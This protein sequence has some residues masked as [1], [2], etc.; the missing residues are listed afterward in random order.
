MLANSIAEMRTYGEGFIIADQSPGLLDLS[1]IRNTNT[2]I[3]LR[4]PD[5]SD[6][7]LVGRAAGLGDKQIVELGRLEKGVAAITQSDW[8][9]PVLCKVDKYEE[10]PRR[11]VR[12]GKKAQLSMNDS[13]EEPA[14]ET[15]LDFIMNREDYRKGDRIDIQRLWEKIVRSKLD[16]AVKCSFM[17]YI[18]AEG[19]KAVEPLRTL[20]YEFFHADQAIEASKEFSDIKDWST[21]VL[22]RLNPSVKGYTQQQID[23]VLA[24]IVYEQ[25]VRDISYRELFIRFT[26][27][28]R[29]KGGVM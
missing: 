23:L 25:A 9:E 11:G 21:C 8:L 20:A 15:L 26:E 6:R 4:L 29:A 10:T 22:E 17:E 3:I 2:K 12:A 28:F 24:L 1:V 5:F 18:S 19:E 27:V 14:E 13:Q 16:A 7:E